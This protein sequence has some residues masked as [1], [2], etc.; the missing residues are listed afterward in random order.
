MISRLALLGLMLSSTGCGLGIGPK[1]EVRQSNDIDLTGITAV[2]ADTGNGDVTVEPTTNQ[3]GIVEFTKRTPRLAL[4]H[5]DCHGSYRIDGT[6]LVVEVTSDFG[7]ACEI[8]TRIVVPPT[9]NVDVK[10]SNGDAHVQDMLGQVSARSSDGDVVASLARPAGDAPLCNGTFSTNNGNIHVTVQYPPAGG[11]LSAATD[12]G[13]VRIGL[14]DGT[15][16]QVSEHHDNGAFH[17]GLSLTDKAPFTI[18]MKT[19]NGDLKIEKN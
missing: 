1:K 14:S 13:D 6:T 17:N 5:G 15:A 3:A 16:F 19:D 11:R 10:T 7:A 8:D 9:V 18:E 12:N 4:G 2:R